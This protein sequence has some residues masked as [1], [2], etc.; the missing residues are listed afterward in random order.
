MLI[1]HY[2]SQSFKLNKIDYGLTMQKNYKIFNKK[3]PN[4]NYNSYEIED[5]L[6]VGKKSNI[7]A[8]K[9]FE[10]KKLTKR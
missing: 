5:S 9:L 3:W 7:N 8:F 1:H 2:G 10:I 6:L 4:T